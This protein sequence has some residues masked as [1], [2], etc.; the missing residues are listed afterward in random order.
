MEQFPFGLQ[1]QGLVGE[2][3]EPATPSYTYNSLDDYC[4]SHLLPLLAYNLLPRMCFCFPKQSGIITSKPDFF[5]RFRQKTY[6][7]I[8]YLQ[9]LDLKRCTR[10]TTTL[11]DFF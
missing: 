9:T 4:W 3:Y 2:K 11:Y 10:H 8:Y 6:F 1:V 7:H 5:C